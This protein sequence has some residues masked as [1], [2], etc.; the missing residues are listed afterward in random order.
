MP[1]SHGS[2]AKIRV[3]NAAGSLQDL[4]PYTKSVS[5]PTNLDTQDASVLGNTFKTYVVGLSDATVSLEGSF[6][7]VVDAQMDALR[8]AGGS[9]TGGGT[10]SI[11][12]DPQGS[13]T[14]LPRYSTEAF[15]TSYETSAGVDGIA[16]WSAEFQCSAAVTRTTVP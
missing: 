6:D 16:S 7:P 12:Y 10:I 4:S 14:G 11:Q 1:F 8:A 15:L 2:K 3:D 13:T 5:M 9:L